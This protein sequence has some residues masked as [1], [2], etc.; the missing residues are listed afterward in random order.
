LGIGGQR[1]EKLGSLACTF[2]EQILEGYLTIAVPGM[3]GR[4]VFEGA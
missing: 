1:S 3:K 4:Q 2:L